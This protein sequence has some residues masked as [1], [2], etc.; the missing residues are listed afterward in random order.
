MAK[1]CNQAVKGRNQGRLSLAKLAVLCQAGDGLVT[2]MAW[3]RK[4]KMLEN[5]K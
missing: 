3:L 2:H 4:R 5:I 1:W